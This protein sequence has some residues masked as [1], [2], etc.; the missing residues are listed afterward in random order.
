MNYNKSFNFLKNLPRKL[1]S[2]YKKNSRLQFKVDNKS[3]TIKDFDPVTNLDRDF[4]KYI[5]TLIHKSFCNDSIIGEEFE[6]KFSSND[7]QWCIDPID[8]TRAFIIG[9]PTWSNLIGLSFQNKSVLGLANFPE[10]NKYYI[11]DTKKSYVI[12]DKKN[13]F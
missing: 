5:R 8:G 2:F 3:K 9:A 13:L 7:Y 12:K 11:S 4:E 6:D 10:L 1:N